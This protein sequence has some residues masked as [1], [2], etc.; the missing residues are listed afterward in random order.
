[1]THITFLAGVG[2][3]GQFMEA[4]PKEEIAG[5]Q[6]VSYFNQS[7]NGKPVIMDR[8]TARRIGIDA[9]AL[10][11][12]VVVARGYV[13]NGRI[14]WNRQEPMSALR[15]ALQRAQS[16]TLD[17]QSPEIVIIG[18]EHNFNQLMPVATKLK[19]WFFVSAVQGR[20]FPPVVRSAWKD[21]NKINID[22]E[23]KENSSVR[24]ILEQ[25]RT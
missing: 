1:M 2:T 18:D 12:G 13:E 15:D 8:D 9:D 3:N 16:W 6:V 4:P 22:W 11:Q 14:I 20:P 10:T 19:R 17:Q 21:S 25:S 23:I 7:L 5:P 24:W